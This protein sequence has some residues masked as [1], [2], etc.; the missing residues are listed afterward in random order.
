MPSDLT[1]DASPAAASGSAKPSASTIECRYVATPPQAAVDDQALEQNLLDDLPF[2][3][4]FAAA[5]ASYDIE[6]SLL[7]GI[8]I[9]ESSM[10]PD[11]VSSSNAMGLMQI[12]WPLPPI[13]SA[14]LSNKTCS[15]PV[16]TLMQA[17]VT[18]VNCSTI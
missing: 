7:I 15:T 16:S 3:S 11:A 14:F 13:T 1:G 17:H 4:C 2:Q 8:A 5:A 18:C 6:E 9:V 10:D 12:K